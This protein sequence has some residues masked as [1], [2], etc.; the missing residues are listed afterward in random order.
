MTAPWSH[1]ELH[2]VINFSVWLT[3]QHQRPRVG[4]PGATMVTL[5]L[6]GGCT[7]AGLRW[8]EEAPEVPAHGQWTK[9]LFQLTFS[10]I[11]YQ[12]QVHRLVVRQPCALRRVP[13]SRCPAG[14]MRSYDGIT[15]SVPQLPFMPR[16]ALPLT[17]WSQLM[18]RLPWVT[19]AQFRAG[20]CSP[21]AG[22]RESVSVQC[23][24]PHSRAHRGWGCFRSSF[25]SSGEE[26]R[27]KRQL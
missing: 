3:E 23:L 27:I 14:P 25:S 8:H 7:G 26:R 22:H 11:L 19:G 16:I 24:A 9:P 17:S 21:H 18:P 4:S 6:G 13:S 2:V 5:A 12:C 20:P 1:P 10:I 15:D